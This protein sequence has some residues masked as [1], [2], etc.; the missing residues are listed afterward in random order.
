M[1]ETLMI[2]AGV[3]LTVGTALFVDPGLP[4]KIA[5]GLSAYVEEHSLSHVRELTGALKLS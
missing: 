4:M 3:L 2:L 5:E 1:G